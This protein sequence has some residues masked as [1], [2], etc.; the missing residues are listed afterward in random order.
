MC[1]KPHI[2][3]VINHSYLWRNEARRGQEEGRKA[4]PCL[5]VRTHE[6]GYDETEVYIAPITHTKPL[7][8]EQA[9]EIPQAT[10]NRLALDYERLWI[11]T[12]EV[13]RFTWKGPDVQK[14]PSGKFA[15]GHLPPGL[16]TDAIR[17][18][19]DH[20]RERALSVVDRDDEEL[21]K[22]VREFQKSMRSGKNRDTDRE[23]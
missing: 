21:N 20:A 6:N 4:R 19:R 10:K 17:Q 16:T 12:Q 15:Y 3:L 23:R 2:G 14:S 18:V 9:K 8:P 11:I 7:N 5:I 13:N 1:D 22:R